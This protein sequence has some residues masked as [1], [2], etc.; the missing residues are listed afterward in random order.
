MASFG[1]EPGGLTTPKGSV[2]LPPVTMVFA[3]VDGGKQYAAKHRQAAEDVHL[4]LMSVM[5]TVLLQ[6]KLAI[7]T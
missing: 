1:H 3:I 6:V 5:R 2:N 4:Q 7:D